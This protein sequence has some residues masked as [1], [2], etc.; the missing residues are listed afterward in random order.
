MPRKYS[1]IGN[2]EN[3]IIEMWT[4]GMTLREIGEKLGFTHQEMKNF[5]SRYNKKQKRIEEQI[6]LLLCYSESRNELSNITEL[7]AFKTGFKL[8]AGLVI[9]TIT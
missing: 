8:G 5:K 6:D 3:E 1:H 9:E 7:D 4:N 2:Y